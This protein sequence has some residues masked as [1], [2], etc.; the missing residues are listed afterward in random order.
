MEDIKEVLQFYKE[1][2]ADFLNIKQPNLSK[3]LRKQ[4][5]DGTNDSYLTALHREIMTCRKCPLHK[6]KT[7]YVPGEGSLNP[8]IMFI[9]EGPG[10]EEDLQ[11]RP[12]VGKA[13]ALLEKLVLKIGYSRSDVFIGNIVKCRPP[14]N[15]DPEKHEVEACIPFLKKQIDLIVPKVIICLGKVAM[16]NLLNKNLSI[17]RVHGQLFKFNQVPLIPTLHPSYVLHQSKNG[18]DAVSKA[19][20]IIWNDIQQALLIIKN[21]KA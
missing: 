16:N 9:G 4:A 7:N 5:T 11:G 1:I 19:K 8:D 6:T 15:R 3:T 2:G 12:F 10:R 20:W 21:Q 17:M 13:G 18:K 14:G